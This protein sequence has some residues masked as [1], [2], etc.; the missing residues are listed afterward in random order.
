MPNQQP[1]GGKGSNAM[2]NLGKYPIATSFAVLVLVAIVGL[3]ILRHFMGSISIE[4][5]TR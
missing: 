2:G 1:Q 3:V 4:V 5:G